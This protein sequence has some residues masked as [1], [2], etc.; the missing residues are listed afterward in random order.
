MT[1]KADRAPCPASQRWSF[2]A[3]DRF[4]PLLVPAMVD[5]LDHHGCERSSEAAD[6][7]AA[8][9]RIDFDRCSSRFSGSRSAI[10]RTADVAIAARRTSVHPPNRASM[11][12]VDGEP[13][14]V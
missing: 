13:S 3:A 2:N 4:D 10:R 8:D 7:V 6:N 14:W 1:L 5:V 12:A 9:Y 11:R